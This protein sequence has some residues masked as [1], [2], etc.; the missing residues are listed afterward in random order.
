M[1]PR[2]PGKSALLWGHVN[3]IDFPKAANMTMPIYINTVREPISRLYSWYTFRRFLLIKSPVKLTDE[4]KY[5]TFDD[6][7]M[8]RYPEC[9]GAENI[10][11]LVPY[12]C[13]QDTVCTEGGYDSLNRA[14]QN[15]IRYYSVV[16]YIENLRD[17]FIA[18]EHRLPGFFLNA[19]NI[20][21]S[22]KEEENS[23]IVQNKTTKPKKSTVVE[24]KTRIP[25]EYDFYYFIKQRFNCQMRMINEKLLAS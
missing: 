18:L 17:F 2:I 24:L 14:K 12:F 16:G 4:E 6:C 20:F 8:N 15:V 21:D 3:F 9:T 5:R 19:R 10:S 22:M 1:T 25:L 13:G 23:Y 7:V 11:T